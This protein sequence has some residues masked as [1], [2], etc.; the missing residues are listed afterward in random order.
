MLAVGMMDQSIYDNLHEATLAV[1]MQLGY[2]LIDHM[3]VA[4]EHFDKKHLFSPVV[5]NI[6]SYRFYLLQKVTT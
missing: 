4:V 2:I 3:V 5:D 6:L 1:E